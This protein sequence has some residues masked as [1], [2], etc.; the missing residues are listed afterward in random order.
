MTDTILKDWDVDFE[1]DQFMGVFQNAAS[2]EYCEKII[3]RYEYVQQTQSEWDRGSRGDII[4]RQDAGDSP[5]DISGDTY[6]MGG[7][8]GENHPLEEADRILMTIDAPLLSEFNS[9]IWQCY[10]IYVQQK[11]GAVST[12]N[13]HVPSN[14][15]RVQKYKPSQGYHL[16]HCDADCS[17]LSHRVLVV[18]LYLNT[19]NEGGETEF[20]YQNTRVSPIQGTVLLFPTGW[21]HTHRGNP[22]LKDNKYII[23]TWLEFN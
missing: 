18:I 2:N 5:L 8:N 14:S 17:Q 9:I 11:Y 13:K 20:L 22:P 4:S 10:N 6:F 16:W 7:V 1:L 23:T 15:V 12:I 21:T 19:V 3:N